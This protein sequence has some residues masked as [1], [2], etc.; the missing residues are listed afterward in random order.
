[1]MAYV[2]E[3]TS[4]YDSLTPAQFVS[5][6]RPFY[7]DW[8][9]GQYRALS[10]RFDVDEKKKVANFSKGMKMKFHLAFALSHHAKVLILDEPTSGLDPFIR[11][12]FLTL[13]SDEAKDG[14]AVLFSTHITEDV[15]KAASRVM[16]ISAGEI[17]FDL[18][19][20][21]IDRSC[22]R[23]GVKDYH[24]V[25]PYQHKLVGRTGSQCYVWLD[26]SAFADHLPREL[27][28]LCPVKFAEMMEDVNRGSESGYVEAP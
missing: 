10:S 14:I 17:R 23:I 8:D 25:R 24:L 16:Y 22:F 28:L 3:E 5:V 2:C 7:P 6:F 18:P 19:T 11:S 20:R 15:M 1:M 13:I 26:R 21:E 27:G 9:E 4:I 12:E